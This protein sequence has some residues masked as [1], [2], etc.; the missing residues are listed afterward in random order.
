[1][2]EETMKWLFNNG[3]AVSIIAAIF[4]GAYRGGNACM[5]L[6][7]I[8]MK[9]GLLAYFQGQ[10]EN[11]A[12]STETQQ[13]LGKTLDRVCE[14]LSETRRDVASIKANTQQCPKQLAG[15]GHPHQPEKSSG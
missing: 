7:F 1:M 12:K 8:P 9:D 10:T 4:I 15:H 14:E 2:T 3:L 11:T 5:T 13:K 6:V